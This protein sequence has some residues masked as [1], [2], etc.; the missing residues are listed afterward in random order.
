VERKQQDKV[1]AFDVIIP[2]QGRRR[3]P[4]TSA[5]VQRLQV[6]G[7]TDLALVAD[8]RLQR[9]AELHRERTNVT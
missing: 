1:L 3:E 8:E 7:M 4:L 5:T 9:R 2:E 6:Y